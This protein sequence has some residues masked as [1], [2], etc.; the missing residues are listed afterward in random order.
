MTKY[1]KLESAWILTNLVFEE[2]D[3]INMIIDGVDYHTSN[4]FYGQKALRNRLD[5]YNIL[6]NI[7]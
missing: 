3:T 7:L 4:A 2:E 1:I 5:F 6:I